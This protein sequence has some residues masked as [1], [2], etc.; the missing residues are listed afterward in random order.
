MDT[1]MQ[2]TLSAV[3]EVRD[4]DGNLVSAEPVELSTVVSEQELR[5][6]MI[7]GETP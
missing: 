5:A 2:V 3:A 1:R 6:M 7:E 4:Q